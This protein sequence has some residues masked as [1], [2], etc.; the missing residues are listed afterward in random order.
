ML[1]LTGNEV[2]TSKAHFLGHNLGFDGRGVVPLG[3]HAVIKFSE[4]QPVIVPLPSDVFVD[5]VRAAWDVGRSCPGPVPC[6][7]F[8]GAVQAEAAREGQ[9]LLK[10]EETGR[11]R[12]FG[13]WRCL[14]FGACDCLRPFVDGSAF[15]CQL[16]VCPA[17]FRGG[18]GLVVVAEVLDAFQR[19]DRRPVPPHRDP[20][21]LE[22]FT[23]FAHACGA[24]LKVV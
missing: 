9:R 4:P 12:R 17:S 21:P 15:P 22:D 19:R 8:R 23:K 2:D 5:G 1:E 3:R 11:L 7:P 10:R 18:G 13:S 14:S 16:C 24:T 20:K 6:V